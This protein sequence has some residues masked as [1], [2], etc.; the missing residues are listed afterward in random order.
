AQQAV[1]ILPAPARKIVVTSLP[2]TLVAGTTSQAFTF[3]LQDSFGNPSPVSSLLGNVEDSVGQGVSFELT[4][5]ST[6]T[7]M[8]ASPNN[9][10]L[11]FTVTTG[12]AKMV[13]GQHTTTFYM[14]DTWVG[15]HEVT[16]DQVKVHGWTVAVQTYTVTPAPPTV[17]AFINPPRKMIASS[18]A[19]V[20][21][22]VGV[23]SPVFTVQLRDSFGN[24]S[25]STSE[26]QA[27]VQSNSPAGRGSWD[28]VGFSP[29]NAP[30]N[31]LILTYSPGQTESS[32]YYR[33]T[34]AGISTVT[35]S[36]PFSVFTSTYQPVVVTPNQAARFVINHP[37][38]LSS[39]L[40][41]RI[42]GTISVTAKDAY[43]NVANG[44]QGIFF[45]GAYQN[46][47]LSYAGT[48]AFGHNGSTATVTIQPS[49][50]TVTEAD[51]GTFTF[52][53]L[54]TQQSSLL[55][56]SS[57]TVRTSI[58]GTTADSGSSGDVVTSGLVLLADTANS[59]LSPE[60][61][62]RSFLK[63]LVGVAS[64]L[65]QGDGESTASPNP[66]AMLR[67]RVGVRPLTVATTAQWEALRVEKL[68]TVNPDQITEVG[69]WQDLNGDGT[70]D[71]LFDGRVV[72]GLNEPGVPVSTSVFITTVVPVA[73]TLDFTSNP[74]IVSTTE[75][76]FFL[77]IRVS[78][79]AT[80]GT[81]IGYRVL[82]A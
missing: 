55:L 47:G 45:D 46:N 59:D 21:Y 48:A 77:T 65:F 39:P 6:G 8:F 27:H 41:V 2:Q 58:V 43:N 36:V 72:S 82:G 1:T 68:G 69:L 34:V 14:I 62:P 33:D 32:F 81:T 3:Q 75:K 15:Q 31:S 4:S 44:G 19:T 24:I 51:K 64:T 57:D 66:I 53:V 40:S 54:D 67:L 28:N 74:Q 71:A 37:Y 70:F 76:I 78:T 49:S 56:S 26:I 60:P 7:V 16:V 22:A 10:P 12:S 73:A 9:D 38:G 30:S 11:A 20:T 61:E 5:N 50:K 80:P 25:F 29:I 52:Q 42:F 13:V 17:L 79:V 35:V 23:T 18:T 63:N